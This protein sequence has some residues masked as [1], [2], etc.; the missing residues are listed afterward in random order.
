M[1]QKIILQRQ[2]TDLGMQRRQ[3]DRFVT[4]CPATKYVGSPFK[5]LF[6]PFGDLVRMYFKLRSKIGQG[7]IS[8]QGH[9]GNTRL[10]CCVV[11][12]ACP[13]P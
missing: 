7:P 10:E 9:Q 1:F 13:P 5:K 2:L 12:S 4:R 6:L 3:I 8:S 11:G